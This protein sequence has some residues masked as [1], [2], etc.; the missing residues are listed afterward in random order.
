MSILR[1]E[2]FKVLLEFKEKMS[3]SLTEQLVRDSKAI[4]M[5]KAQ[6]QR[7]LEEQ[8]AQQQES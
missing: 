5:E 1:K 8:I 7:E 3:D 4:Y 6:K 2:L